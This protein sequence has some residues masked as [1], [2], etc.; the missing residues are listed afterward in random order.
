M[1]YSRN[2]SGLRKKLVDKLQKDQYSQMEYSS[3]LVLTILGIFC[4]SRDFPA[5]SLSVLVIMSVVMFLVLRTSIIWGWTN[6]MRE[7]D[8]NINNQQE[9]KSLSSSHSDSLNKQPNRSALTFSSEKEV[10]DL[11]QKELLDIKEKRVIE[12]EYE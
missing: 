9:K 4:I 8:I 10:M 12:K 2:H 3:A 7:D 5:M 11:L 1:H 6:P